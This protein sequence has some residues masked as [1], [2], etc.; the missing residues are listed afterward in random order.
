M[1]TKPLKTALPHD[2]SPH[3]S[4]TRIFKPTPLT[5]P[6][7]SLIGSSVFARLMPHYPYTLHCTAPFLSKICPFPWEDLDLQLIHRSMGPPRSPLKW[8]LHPVCC[9]P[10]F[11]VVTNGP[12]DGQNEDETR[13][14]TN[15]PLYAMSATRHNRPT[16]KYV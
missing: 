16:A 1:D 5:V 4:I 10:K 9:F 15:R 14:H 7:G 8:N 3:P 13:L 2:G 12:T 11:T 6:N